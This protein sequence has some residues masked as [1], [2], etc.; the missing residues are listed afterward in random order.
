MAKR[1]RRLVTM[2]TPM[3]SPK[4]RKGKPDKTV[5]QPLSPHPGMGRGSG[6]IATS[7]SNAVGARSGKGKR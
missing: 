3:E 6:G 1:K 5:K 4:S 2:S 7:G